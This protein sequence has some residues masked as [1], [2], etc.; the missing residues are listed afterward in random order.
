MSDYSNTP[1]SLPSIPPKVSEVEEVEALALVTKISP[2]VQLGKL[3][4]WLVS[5]KCPYVCRI[6]HHTHGIALCDSLTRLHHRQAH[7]HSDDRNTGYWI[8][9]PQEFTDRTRHLSGVA[10]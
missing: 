6:G 8:L 10:A 4:G 5:I 9:L 3:V 7:C 1:E 2:N